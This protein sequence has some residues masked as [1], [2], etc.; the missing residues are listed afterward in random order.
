MTDRSIEK[1]V[2][3]LL[4]AGVIL[5]GLIVL[6]GGIYYLAAH[7]GEPVTYRHFMA[8]PAAYRIIGQIVT[9]A[10]ALRAQSVIQLGILVLI[11]T[12]ILRV[13]ASLVGF[14]ME[15]DTKYVAITALVLTL[16][17]YSLLEGAIH[18]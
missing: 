9:G 18:E 6:A 12:P 3:V 17:L 5:S 13:A 8:Q 11:A 16:L 10:F 14:V 7:G 15:R 1:T 4:R 2:S